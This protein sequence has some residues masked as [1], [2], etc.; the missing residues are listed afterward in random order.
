MVGKETKTFVLN[1]T[2][3]GVVKELLGEDTDK[4]IGKEL[5]LITVPVRNPSTKQM[6]RGIRVQL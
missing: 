1:K 3:L 2:N 4:W 5:T 6:T